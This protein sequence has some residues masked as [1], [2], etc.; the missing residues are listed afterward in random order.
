MGRIAF[1]GSLHSGVLDVSLT[2]KHCLKPLPFSVHGCVLYL[3]WGGQVES[4]AMLPC[5]SYLCP[6]C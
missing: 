3:G 1:L 4:L 5:L 2:T 6:A